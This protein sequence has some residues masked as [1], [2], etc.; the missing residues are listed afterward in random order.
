[1]GAFAAPAVYGLMASGIIGSAVGAARQGKAAE[2]AAQFNAALIR[3]ETSQRLEQAFTESRR[4]R[5]SNIVR[6]AKSG[7]RLEGSPLAV[8][9]ENEYQDWKQREFIRM[10]GESSADLMR[11]RGRNARSAARMGIASEVIR[12]A[13]RIG[14]LA[15]R[16][17]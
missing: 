10:S 14:A 12:G 3:Q 17:A 11:A 4:R 5:A 8:I 6:V 7:V 16:N 9:E 15:I 2:R 13:G 1:M